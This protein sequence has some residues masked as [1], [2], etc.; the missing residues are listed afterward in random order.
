LK[1]ERFGYILRAAQERG[2]VTPE[3]LSRA[4]GVSGTTIRR[5]LHELA[6]Q[7]RLQRVHGGA[8]YAPPAVNEPDVV[9]RMRENQKLKECI[10]EAAAGLI[11]NGDSV[12]IGAGATTSH[13]PKFLHNH[14]RLTI[15][16]NSLSVGVDLA[17]SEH[18]TVVVVGGVLR[19]S[20]L[21]LIGHLAEQ[22]LK[23]VHVDKVIIGIEGVGLES[24]L[25]NDF[26]QEVMTDRAIIGMAPELILVTDHTKFSKTK[27]AIVA[28]FSR[29]TTLVTDSGIDEDTIGKIKEMGIRV[30]LV[31]TV[32]TERRLPI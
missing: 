12:F 3:E 20:E 4:L 30:V 17:T 25:T 22:A 23:E 29:V 27:S 32:S 11:S 26:L 10:A 14:S 15:V 7:G 16:T 8:L 21:S 13:I 6:D 1:Q 24:G 18:I 31:D 2:R 9:R 5:D 28:P 19:S